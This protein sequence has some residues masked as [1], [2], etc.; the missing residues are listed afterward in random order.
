MTK[1]MTIQP[2]VK[3]K[4]AYPEKHKVSQHCEYICC[5]FENK[6]K[7]YIIIFIVV[8]FLTVVYVCTCIL[9]RSAGMNGKHHDHNESPAGRHRD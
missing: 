7:Q 1:S 8:L 3:I 6:N 9:R 2:N 5:L 4:E